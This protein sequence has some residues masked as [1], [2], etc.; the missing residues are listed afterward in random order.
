[1]Y[2]SNKFTGL[3]T[4]NFEVATHEFKLRRQKHIKTPRINNG[5]LIA[6]SPMYFYCKGC[7]IQHCTKPENYTSEVPKYCNACETLATH[8]MSGR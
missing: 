5:D 7:L 2:F 4:F 3:G 1:M 6:G 8:G